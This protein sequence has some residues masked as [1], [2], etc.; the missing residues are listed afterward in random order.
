MPEFREFDWV[1]YAEAIAYLEELSRTGVERALVERG[2]P[3]GPWISWL[4]GPPAL[5]IYALARAQDVPE[6]PRIRV[7]PIEGGSNV[8]LRLLQY[9]DQRISDILPGTKGF[10]LAW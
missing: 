3:G 6:R 1:E 9:G 2:S 8:E 4:D 7:G 5:A 10:A